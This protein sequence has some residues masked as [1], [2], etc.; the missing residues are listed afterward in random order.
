MTIRNL[1][2]KLGFP[3]HRC[4]EAPKS[5]S[6]GGRTTGPFALVAQPVYSVDRRV[7]RTSRLLAPPGNRAVE[8]L[9]AIEQGALFPACTSLGSIDPSICC[10]IALPGSCANPGKEPV[11]NPG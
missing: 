5:P 10:S 1:I 6:H 8:Q 9:T 2:A 3:D 4:Q 7:D 11:H